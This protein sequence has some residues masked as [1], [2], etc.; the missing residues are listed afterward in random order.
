MIKKW[1]C[2]IGLTFALANL[3][4]AT[5]FPISGHEMFSQ[6][7][8]EIKP[9]TKGSVVVFMSARCPCSNSHLKIVKE[10]S[11]QFKDFSFVVI[12]SNMDESVEETK[13]YFKAANFN[14]P[15][16]QDENTKLAD[17]FKALKTPHA[18]VLD[19][20]GKILYKGGITNSAM[21]DTADRQLLKDALLDV[22]S[23][24]TVRTPEGR[25][26]GCIISRLAS[27]R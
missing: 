25:T 4:W 3:C 26:L 20:T 6:N 15:V 8:L 17:L 2:L 5:P 21:A 24:L 16:L 13:A 23:G 10:L 19:V 22:E 9:G 1:L 18:Y 12:H 11:S 27:E 7:L 14:F